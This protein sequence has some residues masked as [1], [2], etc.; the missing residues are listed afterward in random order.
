MDIDPAWLDTDFYSTLG[1]SPDATK[2]DITK[3][4]P[5]PHR[6]GPRRLR[7]CRRLRRPVRSGRGLRVRGRGVPAVDGDGDL[8]VTVHV[9]ERG[10]ER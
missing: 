1:V 2:A 10:A 7:G 3:A 4:Y 8:L 5:G 9:D 6:R